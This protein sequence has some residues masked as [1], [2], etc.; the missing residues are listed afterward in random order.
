M[1]HRLLFLRSSLDRLTKHNLRRPRVCLLRQADHL[2]AFG[3][4]RPTIAAP[5]LFIRRGRGRG[6]TSD[7]RAAAK[8]DQLDDVA[9]GHSY[10]L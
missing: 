7:I 5:F 3:C 1:A 9:F 4:D 6:S 2:R 8:V 10:V